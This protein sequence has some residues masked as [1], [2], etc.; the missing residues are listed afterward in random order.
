MPTHVFGRSRAVVMGMLMLAVAPAAQAQSRWQVEASLDQTGSTSMH[1]VI[2]DG[3]TSSYDAWQEEAVRYSVGASALARVASHG[4]LRLGLSLSNKGFTERV[5][6]SSPTGNQTSERNVDLLYLGAP[7]TL[8]YNLASARRG[9]VPVAEAG[10]VAEVLLR[11]DDSVFEYD[12]RDAGLSYLVNAGV[13]YTLADGRALVLAP[14]LRIAAQP[15]SR[16][17]PNGR[18]FRPV[19]VGLKL[20]VQF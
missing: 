13:K 4:S 20:G 10:V 2:A 17:T 6:T 7:L 15:Y 16:E 5:T 14:E 8:G 12:L 3:P 9:I 11:E 1:G 19:T 18:E